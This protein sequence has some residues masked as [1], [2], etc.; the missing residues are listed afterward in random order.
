MLTIGEFSRLTQVSTKALRYYDDI[1]L[2]KPARVDKFTQYRYYDVAQLPRLY[3]IL[4]LKALGL[5]LEQISNMLMETLSP[6]EMRGMLR[7][8]QAELNEQMSEVSQRLSYV[9]SK[10]RQL[11]GGS[12]MGNYDVILKD[13]PEIKVALARGI[14]PEMQ[15]MGYVITNLFRDV[16]DFV[17]SHNIKPISEPMTLYFDEEYKEEQIQ[18][19]A[20]F[21]IDADVEPKGDITITTLPAFT[22]ASVIHAGALSRL[23][24]AYDALLKWIDANNYQIVGSNREIALQYDPQG[25]P[26]DYVTELQFPVRKRS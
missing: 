26:E 10:I 12:T 11:E 4:A 15:T 19:G 21:P 6:E 24:N 16:R 22:M 18:V 5:S 14:S 1:D 20:A 2:F 9:E 13:V 8:K 25:N 17:D 23:S 7:L 3:R